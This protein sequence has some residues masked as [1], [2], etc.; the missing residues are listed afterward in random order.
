MGSQSSVNKLGT[1]YA[2]VHEPTGKIYVG[3]TGDIVTRIATHISNLRNH[4]HPCI[5]MQNDF[6]QYGD[7]YR[8]YV[9]FQGC[10]CREDLRE[11]EFLFMSLL[12]TRNPEIGYN[13]KD[14]SHEFSLSKCGMVKVPDHSVKEKVRQISRHEIRE[15]T[16]LESRNKGITQKEIALIKEIAQ[17]PDER[18]DEFLAMVKGAVIFLEHLRRH[19]EKGW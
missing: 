12:K 11:V 2:L 4:R 15:K 17:I 1:V 13:D 3:S 8:V 9:L 6:D 14:P 5:S 18:Q 10:L 19:K 7:G 16:Q